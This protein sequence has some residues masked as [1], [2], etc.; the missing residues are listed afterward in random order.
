MDISGRN[1]NKLQQSTKDL[2][3]LSRELPKKDTR[4]Q[5]RSLNKDVS[6]EILINNISNGEKEI[7]AY[8]D[9][10]D[11]QTNNREKLLSTDYRGILK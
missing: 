8:E 3:R 10:T 6:K 7:F 1:D 5:L 11:T 9:K 2:M 4:E